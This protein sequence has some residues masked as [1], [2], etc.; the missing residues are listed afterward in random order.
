MRKQYRRNT[1]PNPIP[2]G[3]AIRE[4][5]KSPM[6]IRVGAVLF[7]DRTI[8]G[9]GYSHHPTYSNPDKRTSI[10]AEQATLVGLRHDIISGS[11]IVIV[12]LGK[13]GNLLPVQPC[14]RC[15]ALLKKKGVR[16]VHCWT[17]DMDLTSV[18][19]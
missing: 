3:I 5:S 12:R 4:A 11:D 16:K 7:K 17:Q 2:I 10:H 8:L 9:T 1:D 19:L 15:V 13:S 18:T 6:Q 14:E